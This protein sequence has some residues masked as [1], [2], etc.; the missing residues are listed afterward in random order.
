MNLLDLDL[1]AFSTDD[2]AAADLVAVVDHSLPGAPSEVPP[3]APV[4]IVIDHHATEGIETRILFELVDDAVEISARSTD[5]WIHLGTVPE[6][7]FSDAGSAGGHRQMAGVH[8][9]LGLFADLSREDDSL[10]EMV[11]R[12]VSERLVRLST[13]DVTDET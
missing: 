5:T 3:N 13:R 9:P 1:E 2:L 11:E 6:D 12:I 7:V 8:V 10:V 4:D